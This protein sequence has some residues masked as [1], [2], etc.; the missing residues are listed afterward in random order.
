MAFMSFVIL[1]PVGDA[2]K[3]SALGRCPVPLSEPRRG[4][5][6]DRPEGASI[7]GQSHA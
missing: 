5:F 4:E 6:R 1:I 3:R 2:E 7:A